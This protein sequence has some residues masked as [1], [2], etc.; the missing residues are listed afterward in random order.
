MPPLNGNGVQWDRWLRTGIPI[1]IYL[2]TLAW[3]AATVS[4]DID[5]LREDMRAATVA[6]R[7]LTRSFDRDGTRREQRINELERRVARL[8]RL[9]EAGD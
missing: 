7:D 9:A 3:G 8:E 1:V 6:I 4:S 5:D 2:L